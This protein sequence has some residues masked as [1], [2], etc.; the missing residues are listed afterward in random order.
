MRLTTKIFV[1]LAVVVV[2]LFVVNSGNQAR[3]D[4][5]PAGQDIVII[6]LTTDFLGSQVVLSGTMTLDRG[7]QTGTNTIECEIIAMQLTGTYLGT[8][9]TLTAGSQ[10][11]LSPSFCIIEVLCGR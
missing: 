2:S 5:I 9:L 3:A 8:A 10:N 4:N 6:N 7:A 1:L 11:G